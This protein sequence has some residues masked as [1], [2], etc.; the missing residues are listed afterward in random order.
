MGLHPFESFLSLTMA[1]D[2]TCTKIIPTFQKLY[3]ELTDT[4]ATTLLKDNLQVSTE[5]F[6]HARYDQDICV[7][8]DMIAAS[9]PS[10]KYSEEYYAQIS[11]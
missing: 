4:D 2:A 5:R 11:R 7:A 8:I 6:K 1:A 3:Q 9:I 10:V